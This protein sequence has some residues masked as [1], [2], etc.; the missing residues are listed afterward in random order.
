MVKTEPCLQQ[1]LY[2]SISILSKIYVHGKFRFRKQH[3]YVLLFEFEFVYKAAEKVTTSSK[4][5]F[6]PYVVNE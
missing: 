4:F 1:E 2:S 6:F 5:W 3:L